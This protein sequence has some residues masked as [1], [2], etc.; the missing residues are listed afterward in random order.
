MLGARTARSRPREPIE[1]FEGRVPM[2]D[3]PPADTKAVSA[4]HLAAFGSKTVR[5][6]Y[7]AWRKRMDATDRE[8]NELAIYWREDRNGHPINLERLK[9][10][11][12][13]LLPVE[14]TARTS[15]AEQIAW[16]LGH[17]KPDRRRLRRGPR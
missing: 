10:L 4:A 15:L 16:D 12:D 3:K 1:G 17:R 13:E 7:S 11:L 2:P 5:R 6:E 8:F 14:A 9:P